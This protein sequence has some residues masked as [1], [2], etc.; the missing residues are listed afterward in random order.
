MLWQHRS[1]QI[2]GHAMIWN[3]SSLWDYVY[4]LGSA[5]SCHMTISWFH[6][7]RCLRSKPTNWTN[8]CV[9]LFLKLKS[10]AFTFYSHAILRASNENYVKTMSAFDIIW[11]YF[12]P[13]L[14]YIFYFIYF[15]L[16]QFINSI[17]AGRGCFEI[18]DRLKITNFVC[19][20]RLYISPEITHWL[21]KQTWQL[22]QYSLSQYVMVKW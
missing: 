12:K 13:H 15:I 6:F 10:L 17:W 11:Q 4:S 19:L 1:V 20:K 3:S 22:I 2:R 18:R 7:C 9:F 21:V 5:S 16:F 14:F 8:D